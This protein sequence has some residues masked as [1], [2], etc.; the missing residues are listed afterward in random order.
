MWGRPFI[1]LREKKLQR[2]LVREEKA[3]RVASFS[4][5]I[6]YEMGIIAHSC[7]VK[8]PRELMRFHARIVGEHRLPTP[9][10]VVHPCPQKQANPLL[11]IL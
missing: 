9:L 4:K 10:D 5:N 1:V 8:E 3:E 6:A 7:G 11:V 2:G